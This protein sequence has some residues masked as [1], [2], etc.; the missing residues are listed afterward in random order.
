VT[1]D[2]YYSEQW[3][4]L[5][6]RVGGQTT[7]Q[8]VWS[9][10]YVDA[11]VLRDRDTDG[12]G[13]LDERLWVVQ[14]ANFNVTALLDDSGEVVERYLY[15]PFGQATVLDAN[16]NVRSGGSAYDWLYLHQGG[17][18]DVTSGLY[19]FRFRDY[20]PTLGRW[21]SLDPL[22]F[23]AGDAN[24][25]RFVFNAPTVFT[26]PSGQA[27]FIPLLIIGGAALLGVAGTAGYTAYESYRTTGTAFNGEI[28]GAAGEGIVFVGP[29]VIVNSAFDAV[30]SN[31]GLGSFERLELWPVP[32]EDRNAYE[33]GYPGSR[34]L[35][36]LEVALLTRKLPTKLQPYA[37]AWDATQNGVL[38]SRGLLDVPQITRHGGGPLRLE[39]SEGMLLHGPTWT[40]STDVILGLFG[41]GSNTILLRSRR[42]EI[43]G[44]R[45]PNGRPMFADDWEALLA[46]RY[47]PSNVKR[48]PQYS[49]LDDIFENP[50]V[51]EDLSPIQVERKVGRTP[52][53]RVETLRKGNKEGEGWVLREYGPKG[54]PTGRMLRWH[55]GGGHHGPYP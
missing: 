23:D 5:E 3:Q 47:G 48:I 39:W 46:E 15:D 29:R 8:Y 49:T 17:R 55:P 38:V 11:L 27:I 26:D 30:A 37:L 22:G 21:T 40:N 53:W 6:E 32:P 18:Y 1:T 35:W 10:V 28:W 52:G 41:A 13:T 33:L 45:G 4:V 44:G 9:P 2:F 31:A 24:L 19:H 36:E 54:E 51:L 12:D 16:W 20:S 50:L 43:P 14:D 25:Y 42:G 7:V 34:L